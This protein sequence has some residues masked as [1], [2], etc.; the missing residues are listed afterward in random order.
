MNPSTYRGDGGGFV[1]W[2][3][4]CVLVFHLH[5]KDENVGAKTDLMGWWP[6]VRNHQPGIES[7]ILFA[8]TRTVAL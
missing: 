2:L 3:V 1:P 5:A 4:E 8:K 7:M 6:L